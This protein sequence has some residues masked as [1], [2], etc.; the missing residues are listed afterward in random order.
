[1][2]AEFEWENKVIFSF[3]Y[4]FDIYLGVGEYTDYWI[5][6]I[7]GTSYTCDKYEI[8]NTGSSTW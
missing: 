6:T 8:I 4:I 7:F 3:I 1:M 2:W 5:A